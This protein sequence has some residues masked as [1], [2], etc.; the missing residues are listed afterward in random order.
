MASSMV[1]LSIRVRNGNAI[2]EL[3][4]PLMIEWE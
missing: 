2:N 3:A 4:L 1:S